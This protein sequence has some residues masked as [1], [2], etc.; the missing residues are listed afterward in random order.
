M[1]GSRIARILLECLLQLLFRLVQPARLH[2]DAPVLHQRADLGVLFL[3]LGHPRLHLLTG[4]TAFEGLLLFGQGLGVR[5][6][7]LVLWIN[8][9]NA[10]DPRLGRQQIAVALRL[11]GELDLRVSQA[12]HRPLH[13]LFH[14]DRAGLLSQRI[15]LLVQPRSGGNVVRF[16]SLL[17]LGQALTQQDG[18]L[19]AT[20]RLNLRLLGRRGCLG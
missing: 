19:L 17:R 9:Q 15:G 10:L 2:E 3:H 7:R 6:C 12:A 11:L 1:G 13:L 14:A 18:I 20:H 8:R 16:L 5:L 4:Q